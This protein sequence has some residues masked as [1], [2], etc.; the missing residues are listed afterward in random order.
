MQMQE[1]AFYFVSF[2]YITEAWNITGVT[3]YTLTAT[4]EPKHN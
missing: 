2:C 1:A 3:F 4:R